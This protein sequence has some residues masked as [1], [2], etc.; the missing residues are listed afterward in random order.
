VG[1]TLEHTEAERQQAGTLPV[2]E[3]AEV[4]D[5]DEAAW[6]QVQEEA[7]QKLAHRQAHHTLPVATRG[8][9]PAEEYRT[10]GESNEPTVGDADTMGV[11]TEIAEDVLWSAE[12][13]LRIDHP[14]VTEQ[15]S[16]PGSEAAWLS[17]RFEMAMELKVAI[18]ESSLQPCEE[19]AAED[20]AE[21]LDRKEE[22][23]A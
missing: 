11:R 17:Q 5:A 12:W 21:Y 8:V 3:E 15:A 23:A 10:I 22:G 6:E 19:L 2:G 13:S 7:P 4:T 20:T 14:I 16:E 18:V 9:S 1:R